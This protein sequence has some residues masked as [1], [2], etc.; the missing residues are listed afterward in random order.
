M[1]K[2]FSGDKKDFIDYSAPVMEKHHKLPAGQSNFPFISTREA[3]VADID[4]PI[5]LFLFLKD[6]IIFAK[7]R[8]GIRQRRSR[9]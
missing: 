4:A 7:K 8:A 3:L 2:Y 1:H 6:E 9:G 5:L